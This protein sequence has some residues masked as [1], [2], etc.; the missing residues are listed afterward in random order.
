MF[1]FFWTDPI[2]RKTKKLRIKAKND[3]NVSCTK[4]GPV[5]VQM[6]YNFRVTD[7]YNFVVYKLPEPK[8]KGK[9][10]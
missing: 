7:Y 5:E 4:I 1:R 9:F 6:R 3:V 10:K 2:L 8:V